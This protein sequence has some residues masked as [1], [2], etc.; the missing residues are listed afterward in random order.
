MGSQSMK[1]QIQIFNLLAKKMLQ[2]NFNSKTTLNL[3]SF[4][5]GIYVVQIECDGRAIK[6]SKII[7]TK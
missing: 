3:Q 6:R 5:A 1:C 7:V 4:Q 2:S